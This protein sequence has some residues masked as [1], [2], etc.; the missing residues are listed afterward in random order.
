MTAGAGGDPYAK[1]E[2]QQ[3]AADCDENATCSDTSSYYRCVC[4][5]GFEGDGKSCS[6]ID[7]CALGTHDCSPWADCTNTIPGSTDEPGFSCACKPD[8]EGDGKDCLS[9]YTQLTVGARHSCAIRK[10]GTA[11]CWGSNQNGNGEPEDT[12]MLGSD[13]LATSPRP[14]HVG[15][16]GGSKDWLSLAASSDTSLGIK[17][18]GSLWQWGQALGGAAKSA[19][20]VL[21]SVGPYA[22]LA[23]GASTHHCALKVGGAL[24]CW[25]Q[26][27]W[28]KL[29][30]GGQADA[31]QPVVITV[32]GDLTIAAVAVGAEHTCA[33]ATSGQLYCWGRNTDGQLGIGTTTYSPT[34]VRVGS[35]TDWSRIAA[36]MR[37]SCGVKTDGTLHC[38]GQNRLAQLGM[39]TSTTPQAFMAPEWIPTQV[40]IGTSWAEVAAFGDH[41]CALKKAGTIF[42]WGRSYLAGTTGDGP[43]H[44]TEATADVEPQHVGASDGF[45]QIGVGEGH[46]CARKAGRILCWGANL[47]GATGLGTT[48]LRTTAKPL[49][50]GKVDTLSAGS[51]HACAIDDQGQLFCWGD[52]RSGQLGTGDRVAHASPA[53]VGSA[54]DWIAVATGSNYDNSTVKIAKEDAHSCAIRSPNKQ[55]SGELYCWGANGYRQSGKP[56]AIKANSAYYADELEPARIGTAS[57]WAYVTVGLRFGCAQKTDASVHCWGRNEKGE[58]GTGAGTTD[59]PTS[60]MG[61]FKA[62]P[63]Q[64]VARDQTVL[65]IAEDG[66]LWGWGAGTDALLT[67]EHSGNQSAPVQLGTDTDWQSVTLGARHAC[68]TKTNGT[69][70]CWGNG[71]YGKLGL[72]S[73]DSATTPTL[74]PT[75]SSWRAVAAT[76]G[77]STCGLAQEPNEGGRL[78]CWGANHWAQLA[79]GDAGG[80]QNSPM[81]VSPAAS[82]LSV[83]MGKRYGCAIDEDRKAHCWGANHHGKTGFGH[84][85]VSVPTP[86]IEPSPPQ[87]TR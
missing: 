58:Q 54:S 6:D 55:A 70:H 14:I 20:P 38:W 34:P 60:V 17:Q 74:V 77:D 41:T 28:G 27:N 57:D 67:A 7:E 10:G 85:W 12:F 84:A 82:W 44:A 30:N 45:E 22:A 31:A 33:V 4:K 49:G 78:F 43:T 47:H 40:G 42:C 5:P 3:G 69:L 71:T 86:V 9:K 68:A 87:E 37:H 64:V 62:Q 32:G 2:C 66:T 36:G 35:A 51:E 39:V 16:S 61:N 56:T 8:F 53:Q 15:G 65:A 72:G 25:G 48:G 63:A 1:D 26:K 81:L 18:D 19:A 46:A 23:T 73:T 76:D 24:H 52:N 79:R 13:A 50:L 83:H 21:L 59:V 29:G 11:L 75:G 80:A